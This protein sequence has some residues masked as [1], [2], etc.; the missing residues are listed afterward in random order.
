VHT[1]RC[2][3]DGRPFLFVNNSHAVHRSPSRLHF[4]T[5]DS[6]LL[7][8]VLFDACVLPSIFCTLMGRFLSEAIGVA[9]ELE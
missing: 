2:D 8:F 1:I 9:K 4:F 5:V 3:Q 7:G 6:A